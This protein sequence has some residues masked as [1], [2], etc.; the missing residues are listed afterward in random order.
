V[1][2]ELYE[3]ALAGWVRPDV[4]RADG[5]RM[6]LPVDGWRHESP[7]DRS[8]LDRCQGPTLD[9]GSGLGRLT[10]ALA[11]RGIPT[12]GIDITPYAVDLAR[13][14]GALV[15]LRD[16]FGRIPG[17]GRWMTVLLADGNIGIG[18]DPAALLRRAGELLA[19]EGRALVELEPPGRP[20]R[21]DRVRLRHAELT[22]PWFPW[23]FV[24]TD[25][26][27]EVARDAGL[28]E[29]ETWT[30]DGRW[31]AAIGSCPVS[32]ERALAT[33]AKEC[34]RSPPR[35]TQALRKMAPCAP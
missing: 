15:M 17:T 11:E 21:R 14:S 22:G 25:H 34:L 27:E 26:I 9:I 3:H 32:S 28:G 5:S 13:S 18:G 4:E 6:P 7:A 24:G 10:V 12:L 23:A 33:G 29:V 16:V 19:P 8:I 31:F 2:G 20:L 35:T 1:I 30:A